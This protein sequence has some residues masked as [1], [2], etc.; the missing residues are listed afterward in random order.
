MFISLKLRVSIEL[1]DKICSFIAESSFKIKKRSET[2]YCTKQITLSK[3][4]VTFYIW[5][6]L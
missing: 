4:K 2:F 1:K 5:F 3:I 6:Y